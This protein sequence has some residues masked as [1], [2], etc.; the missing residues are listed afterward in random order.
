MLLIRWWI[1]FFFNVA[2]TTE[3]YTY[4]HPLSLHDALPISEGCLGLRGASGGRR[5][6]VGLARLRSSA[7]HA[8][9]RRRAWRLP[10]R[11]QARAS[12]TTDRKSTRLNSSH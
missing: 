2:A 10:G 1:M 11:G 4:L 7:R 6:R 12:A 8:R 5:D 3:I 9:R